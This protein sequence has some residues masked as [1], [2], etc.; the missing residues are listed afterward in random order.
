MKAIILLAIFAANS[1]A[2]ITM[3]EIDRGDNIIVLETT[4]YSAEVLKN[5]TYRI[6]GLEETDIES[7][8]VIIEALKPMESKE[9]IIHIIDNNGTNWGRRNVTLNVLSD[10]GSVQSKQI[11]FISTVEIPANIDLIQ[12]Y[13]NPFNPKT[14]ISFTLNKNARLNTTE[15]L[16][17]NIQGQ[18]VKT[19][20]KEVLN[21]G[22]YEFE[23]DGLNNEGVPVSSGLYFSFLKNGS[24]N[25]AKMMS[26]IK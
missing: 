16:I 1:F 12:N 8:E 9:V 11:G 18:V 26:L 15:L 20:C 10:A 22:I 5:L 4:N 21:E 24:F 13:P 23:W 19:L 7:P 17:V 14:R 6:E 25:K 3:V 2:Q